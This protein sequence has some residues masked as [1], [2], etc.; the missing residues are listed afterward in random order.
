MSGVMSGTPSPQMADNTA[1]FFEWM[2][3]MNARIRKLETEKAKLT[4]K[5][6]EV[7]AAGRVRMQKLGAEKAELTYRLSGSVSGPAASWLPP[8]RFGFGFGC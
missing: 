2:V 3:S 4:N 1:V 8:P 7:E 6:S 5:L